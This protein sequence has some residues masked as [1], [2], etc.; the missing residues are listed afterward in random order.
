MSHLSTC[1][2]DIDEW[3][4]EICFSYCHCDTHYKIFTFK[5]VVKT[6]MNG[7]WKFVLVTIIVIHTIKY[8]LLNHL[9]ASY[10]DN[11]VR[12]EDVSM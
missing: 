2:K 3:S 9:N 7:Q 8:L 5:R 1:R 10:F 11:R 4:M 12:Y 6:L